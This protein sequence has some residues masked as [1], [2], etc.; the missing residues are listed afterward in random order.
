[1]MATVQMFE[2]LLFGVE[3]LDTYCTR[4]VIGVLFRASVKHVG[5]Q[6]F[7]FRIEEPTCG[8]LKRFYEDLPVTAESLNKV[9]V[10][11]FIDT[12][13]VSFY[14][15][16]WFPERGLC[17][18]QGVCMINTLMMARLLKMLSQCNFRWEQLLAF[19][20]FLRIWVKVSPDEF[21]YLQF[22]LG[23]SRSI[24]PVK[25]KHRAD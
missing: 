4:S 23:G 9:R 6:P 12:F 22:H 16:L 20:A 3:S 19:T 18:L 2:K 10:S 13:L 24:R 5:G 17:M 25:A 8:I 7:I 21:Q 1:M 14:Q 11:C 15:Q